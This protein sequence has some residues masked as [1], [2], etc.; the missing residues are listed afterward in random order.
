M[1]NPALTTLLVFQVLSGILVAPLFS[2]LP[3]YVEKELHLTP[4]VSS[5]IRAFFVLM[6]GM[7]AL[8]GGTVCDRLG[9]KPAYLLAMTGV[10]TAGLLFLLHDRSLLYLLALYSGMMF[11]LGS[12]AGQA[13]LMETAPDGTLALAT[14]GYFMTGTLGNAVGSALSGWVAREAANGYAVLGLTMAGGN[15]ALLLLAARLLPAL[16]KPAASH[17]PGAFHGGGGGFFSR[18]AIWFLLGLRFLPTVYWAA[19]TFLMPLLLF[20]LTGS[21]KTAG[22]YTSASLV[23]AAVCQVGVGRIVDRVGVRAPVLVA[24]SLVAVATLGQALLTTH[25]AALIAFGLLGAGAAWSLS[26]TMTTLVRSLSTEATRARLLGFA[27]W[28]WSAGFLTGTLMSGHLVRGKS[29]SGA[30]PVFLICAGCC[31]LAVLCAVVVVSA[32]VEPE[33]PAPAGS[34]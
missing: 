34:S 24:V 8:V 3:I 2:L 17:E 4:D 15:A 13:Y 33:P 6:G 9:R 1:L 16:P 25:T 20:R 28:A 11:G 7:V 21:E 22:Y 14:A 12:V 31:A 10:V 18:P 26:I 5:N 19:A 27:H 30:S 29:P 23:L 32:A